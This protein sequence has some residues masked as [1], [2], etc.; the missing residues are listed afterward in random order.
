M[1]NNFLLI[2]ATDRSKISSDQKRF[3][4]ALRVLMFFNFLGI[5]T[6]ITARKR[7]SSLKISEISV[8]NAVNNF[9]ILN[10]R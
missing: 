3:F 6:W 7:L 9:E 5:F 1:F 2:N 4:I 8:D 10:E